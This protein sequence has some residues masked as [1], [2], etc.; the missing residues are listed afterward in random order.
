[1]ARCYTKTVT[2]DIDLCDLDLDKDDV[3]ELAQEY[4]LQVTEPVVPPPGC[5]PY[6]STV[7]WLV[8]TIEQRIFTPWE[9]ERLERA[10]AAARVWGRRK[11]S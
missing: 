7:D 1:M 5:A 4:G 9:M 10:M 2:I 8:E 6:D 11:A 3:I